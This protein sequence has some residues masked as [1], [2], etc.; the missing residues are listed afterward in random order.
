M[1]FFIGGVQPRTVTLK[2]EVRVCSVCGHPEICQKRVDHYLSL[3]FIPFFPVKKGTP[4]WVC[5]NCGTVYNNS[6]TPLTDHPQDG[7]RTCPYC[8][9]PVSIDYIFCPYCGKTL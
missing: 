8:G 6:G 1:F 9:K 7:Q 4:F 2:K 5:E 3:F